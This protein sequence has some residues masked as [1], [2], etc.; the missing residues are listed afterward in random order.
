MKPIYV[1]YYVENEGNQLFTM[2]LKPA[3]EG[4]YPTAFLRTPYDVHHEKMSP[5]ELEAYMIENYSKWADNG[6]VFIYAH[7][8][9]TANSTGESDAFIYEETD[10]K[11]TLNWIRQQPFYNGEIYLVAGSYCGFVNRSLA[12][13]D[14]DIKSIILEATDSNLYNWLYL[15]GIYRANLH[16][17][18]YIPRYKN[19]CGLNKNF[20]EESFLTLPMT[21]FS[22]KVFGEGAPVFDEMLLHPDADDEF[23]ET[24]LAGS[25]QK[26]ALD[27]ADFPRVVTTGFFDI[28]NRGS[29]DSW[30]SFDDEM[31]SRCAFI[32][33]PYHHGG[34]SEEQP[35][36]FPGG[37]VEEYLGDLETGWFNHVRDGVPFNAPL[38]KIS[39]YELFGNKWYTEDYYTQNGSVT[40]ALGDGERSYV[41]DPR[42]PARFNGGLSNNFGGTVFMDPPNLREDIITCYSPEFAEDTHVRGKMKARLKV[43]SDREDTCFYVRI[44]IVKPEGD[45]A[46]RDSITKISNFDENYVPGTDTYVDFT[47]DEGAFLIKKGEKL[48]IDVS[49]S[50][51]PQFIP[52]TNTRGLFSV[53]TEA[54]KAVNTV[55]LEESTLTISH[56]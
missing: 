36:H 47:F 25:L 7:C 48:R 6:Y 35:Y 8:R 24:P 20:T 51:F 26:H 31:K 4:K 3:K 39:Y 42:N 50:A 49:S 23:W 28:F 37:T 12:P 46:L 16:G 5:S 30:E 40:F 15:N 22:K 10:G 13:F 14:S 32:I 41:Y 44:A 33:H 17:G 19:K 52:H 34:T 56:M 43:R 29:H 2:V 9:G 27:N 38:G 11:A 18:W 21:D 45:F 54:V 53:Q 55:F 1:T